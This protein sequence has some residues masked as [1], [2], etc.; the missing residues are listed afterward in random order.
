[1]RLCNVAHP[2]KKAFSCGISGFS[3]RQQRISAA[4]STIYLD[5][6]PVTQYR[7][8]PSQI[9]EN[10]VFRRATHDDATDLDALHLV[11]CL[12]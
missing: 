6:D 1:V 11:S 4:L 10:P 2:S 12:L 8:D 9:E 3:P 5:Q 7:N